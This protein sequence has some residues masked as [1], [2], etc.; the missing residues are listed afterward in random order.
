MKLLIVHPGLLI[1]KIQ[2]SRENFINQRALDQLVSAAEKY[3]KE[4]KTSN[5]V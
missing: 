3:L 2:S 1:E 5:G 4:K